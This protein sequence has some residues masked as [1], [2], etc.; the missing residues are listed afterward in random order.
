MARKVIDIGAIGNDGTGDSI[1]DSFRKVNDNF[2]ELYSSLGLG[3]RLTFLGLDDTPDEYINN[4]NKILAVNSTTDGLIFKEVV[5]VVGVIVDNITNPNQIRLSTEF[6]EI[7]ADTNPQLGGDLSARS[8]GNQFRIVDL[9]PF[10]E[11]NPTPGGP[12]NADEAVSKAY[13][14]SKISRAGV[15]AVNPATGL[16]TQAFGTMTGPLVL[17]RDPEPDDDLLYDGKVAVTKNYV[18]NA[19]FSSIVNLYVATSGV[20]DRPGV[21]KNSQGRSLASAYRT[22]E[23]ACKRAEEILLES[24]LDIGPY[25]K[26][27][28]YDNGTK[29]CTL[30]FIASAPGSGTGFVGDVF[31]SVGNISLNFV[32]TNY[33][34]GDLITVA[35]GIGSA[36]I[37]QVLTTASTPGP[38]L[39]FRQ[40]SSG[41]YSVLPGSINVATTTDSAFGAGA[42][43]NITYKVNS[44]TI[45]DKGG[46]LSDPTFSDYGLVSVRISGG[47]GS[48]AFGAAVVVNGQI[49]SITIDDQGSGFTSIPALIVDLPRFLLK[50]EGLR[51]DFTGDVLTSTP[52]AFRT[53]D[54]REGLFLKGETTGALAQILAHDGSLD[55]DGNEIFDVDIKF[56]SFQVGEEI[57]YGD[58]TKNAQISILVESGIY[59]E[60]YPLKL[61]QNVAIIGDEFRR[62]IIKPKPGTSSSPWAFQR[63]RRDTIIDGL[64]VASQLYGHHYLEDST[65]PV[66]PKINNKGAY[67][68][69]SALLELNRSFIQEEVI[70]WINQ[71]IVTNTAP[72]TISFVY[73]QALYK[74][75][76]GLIIDALVFDLKYGAYNRTISAGL[77]YKGSASGLV[78]ISTQLSQTIASIE[79]LN[80]L[81]QI[82]ILNSIISSP[83]NSLTPQIFDA[84]FVAERGAGA[85]PRNINA[86]TNSSPV[87]VTVTSNHGY[88]DKEE[89]VISGITGGMTNLNGN[90]Y[91]AQRASD[92]EIDLYLD[93]ELTIPVNGASWPLYIPGSGGDIIPQGGVIGQ[94]TEAII[95]V[96]SNSASVNY[97]KDNDKMDVFLC[98]DAN[99]V[100]AMTGQGHGGFMMVLDPEGQ[101]LA[102]SPYCQESASFSRSINAQTF[103]GGLFV[104]GFT[105]NLQYKHDSSADSFNISVS[106]LDRLP[107]TPCSFIVNDAV[108]RINYVRN[109]V[110]NKNGSTADFSLD[111]TTPFTLPAGPR[112][113]TVTPGNPGVFD[114]LDHRLQTGAT[115]VFTSTGTLPSPLIAGVEYYVVA[116]GLGNN[117]FSVSDDPQAT[118][119]IQILSAGSG[120]LRYQRVYELLMSGNRSMLSNDYTQVNDLGYGVIVTNGGL[121]EAVSMFTYYCHISYYSINGGQIRSIGGS[122]AN[123]NFALVAE[124]ADPL[125]IPTPVTIYG[126]FSQRVVAYAPTPSFETQ[127]NDLFVFVTGYKVTP[128]GNSEL[129]VDHGNQIFR[130]PV[131]STTTDEL[132]AGV[133][134]L[135]LSTD[136]SGNSEGLFAAIADGTVMTHR[137][138]G[139]VVLTGDI[140]DVATRPSTGLILNETDSVY[141]VL[142]FQVYNDPNAPYEVKFTTPNTIEVLCSIITINTNVCTTIGNHLLEVGDKF[143]PESTSSGLTSGTT[144]YVIDVPDY[145]QFVLS[146]SLG[147]SAATLINGTNL[148]LRG[149]KTHKQL[150]NYLVSFGLIQGSF[151]ADISGTTMTVAVLDTGVVRP[152]QIITGPGV[153]A[154]TVITFYGTG[155]GGVGTYI[156]SISQ[157]VSIDNFITT[158]A[159]PSGIISGETYYVLADNLTD[160]SFE[161]S[162]VKNGSVVSFSTAGTGLL[163]YE[164]EGLGLTTLRENYNY[165]DLTVYQPGEYATSGT[166]CTISVASPAVITSSGPHGFT[167]GEVI[168]FTTTGTLPTGISLGR[169]FF[170]KNVLGATT[171]TISTSPLLAGI[172]IDTTGTQAGTQSFGIVTGDVGDQS[173]AVVPVAPEERARI[174]NSVFY[175]QGVRYV[176]TV[177]EDET[178]T[179]EPYARITLDNPLVDP[180]N[181]FTSSYTVKSAVS[182]RTL[183]ANGTLTIRISLTRVTGHDLLEIGTGGYADTN[184]PNEIYGPSVNSIDASKETEERDVGRVFFVTTDQFGNFKVG[185][186]FEVDQGTGRVTFAAAIALSNLDGIGFKRGVPIAEFSID[187]G[188]S[189]NAIDTVPTE[190]ATRIYIERRLG[191]THGGGPV[192]IGQLIPPIS[193]GFLSLDGQ[194]GMKNQLNMANFKIVNVDDPT[195]PTDVVNLRSLTFANAQDLTLNDIDAGDIIVFTGGGGDA[196]NATVIGD[197][198]FTLRTGIDSSLNQVDVQILPGTIDNADV[199]AAAAIQQSKLNMLAAS[200]RVNA[201]GITQADRGLAS[202]DDAQ[203][204]STN[205]WITVK[206]NGLVSTKIEQIAGKNVLGNSN[207]IT[208]NVTAVPFTTVVAD[209]G[210]IKK[211]QYS[212]TGFLRRAGG[213]GS[214]DVDYSVIDMSAAYTGAT[215][216]DKLVV[217]D[218]QGDFGGRVISANQFKID[219]RVAVDSA[220]AG[221]GG[222][223]Q[224]YGYNGQG[225]VLVQD[226]TLAG[227]KKT[228]YW[229]NLHQFK[230]IDGLNDAPITCSSVQTLTLTTGGNTTSGTITGRWTL[231]GTSPNESRLQATYSADL[232]ENYEGDQDYEVGTVLIFGGEKEVTVT[233]VQGD[234]RV[235]GVVSNTAAYTMFEACPGLKN[236]VALQGRVPC[237]VIGKINKGDILITSDIPGVAMAAT[238]D[239]R[240]GTVVGKA[241][242]DYDSNHIGL[243]EIAVGRT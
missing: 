6:S 182:I 3:D 70:A 235:A 133:A 195:D 211:S 83:L 15:N 202:F 121:T 42:T 222:Y 159:V 180:I 177:Y 50:T 125:E 123:G 216:N 187:S 173:F 144:Y 49:D 227:D 85:L 225:G 161:V 74:R 162:L 26:K 136:D 18:D 191:V 120:V 181:N 189:D 234:T 242:K 164:P 204:T 124:G 60:N 232:A 218:N 17:S 103:A 151:Q 196:I 149:V 209:G 51:T 64:T 214:L 48:G 41:L 150:E 104:D 201:T 99:I 25:K 178:L 93:E 117:V 213:T 33:Q 65:S 174:P 94:L 55:S 97:P 233:D 32:G 82:V 73:D 23:A 226:G 206:D 203:F 197:V 54:I 200:T 190:N 185:P 163:A 198:S 140:V 59:E 31:M 141:R 40:I 10:N 86:A 4:E 107:L 1:R 215:E 217:R 230:T 22:I 188:F 158:G 112:T 220:T 165:I 110:Y 143:I 71:Q 24:S 157:S 160:T 111:E 138:N 36:A 153:A 105:G 53:R 135:N 167:G 52:E 128:L 108:F 12:I 224:L 28:T 39:T 47:G 75:D 2:R 154:G 35:G 95:D 16:V 11:F 156:V 119:G 207:S 146:T 61:A 134:R 228:A 179:G 221:S 176:I 13:A 46:S 101:I 58:N 34:P 96:I 116:L 130:Y 194:L 72:F 30:D 100:R 212:A 78:L 122:S 89:I 126:D 199:N 106:G 115:L 63:F 231:S 241:I 29:S 223:I 132:P 193:G 205:G 243:V 84:A 192:P 56:G 183:G 145:D 8:G 7:R 237:K 239:V 77:K 27:L 147:G 139:S 37:Y 87:R 102:K 166:T 129:E 90:T 118:I 170:V 236:L 14:D 20:D 229:N 208:A 44:I 168:K 21:L 175:F 43:F 19:G 152:G 184:Y 171:F 62:V 5:G 169:N 155:T 91:Y 69:A 131:N 76:V 186:F 92:N 57:S 68:S 81:A 38:I 45:T 172:E 67:K 109:F 88:A 142:Q 98:N 238:V 113:F 210:A 80:E 9:P 66:Y 137:N 127:Q 79:K 219:N 114:S 240:V 148:F